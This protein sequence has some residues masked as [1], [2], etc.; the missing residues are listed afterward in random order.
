MNKI[1]L[2]LVACAMLF[3][4]AAN[5]VYADWEVGRWD[6]YEQLKIEAGVIESTAWYWADYLFKNDPA[7]VEMREKWA[8]AGLID[9]SQYGS[10]VITLTPYGIA[11]AKN[12][13]VDL[14]QELATIDVGGAEGYWS[15]ILFLD[16]DIC[17]QWLDAGFIEIVNYAATTKPED[18]NLTAYGELAIHNMLVTLKDALILIG[19]PNDNFVAEAKAK[20]LFMNDDMRNRWA[21]AGLINVTPLDIGNPSIDP[22]EINLTSYGNIAVKN[23]Y[24]LEQAFYGIGITQAGFPESWSD[25]LFTDHNM[26]SLWSKAGFITIHGSSGSVTDISLTYYGETAVLQMYNFIDTFTSAPLNIPGGGVTESIVQNLFSDAYMRKTWEDAGFIEIPTSP[27]GYDVWGVSPAYDPTDF[28]RYLVLGTPT[29]SS[30]SSWNSNPKGIITPHAAFLALDVAPQEAMANINEIIASYSTVLDASYGFHD[31]FNVNTSDVSEGYIALDQAMILI[32]ITNYLEAGVIQD[33]FSGSTIISNSKHLLNETFSMLE[34]P[35]NFSLD[36]NLSPADISTLEDIAARTWNYFSQTVDATTNWIP[37]NKVDGNGDDATYTSI[38]DIGLYLMCVASAYELDLIDLAEA[39]ERIEGALATLATLDKWNGLFRNYYKVETLDSPQEWMRFISTVDNGWLA[40]GLIVVGETFDS[41]KADADTILNAMDFSQLYDA[42]SGF[43][44]IGYDTTLGTLSEGHYGLI[45]TEIR[46]TLLIAIGKDGVPEEVWSNTNKVLSEGIAAQS[47]IPEG[48]YY[49]YTIEVAGVPEE[50]YYIPSWG[51]SMFE[52]LMPNL[53]LNNRTLSPNGYGIQDAVYVFLQ[54]YFATEDQLPGYSI[55]DSPIL[56]TPYGEFSIPG[57]VTLT[58]DLKGIGV[59]KIGVAEGIAITLFIDEDFRTDWEDA[60]Y[61]TTEY[62]GEL[63]VIGITITLLGETE[64]PNIVANVEQAVE[65]LDIAL[66]NN[67][68]RDDFELLFGIS[69][70]EQ[71]LAISNLYVNILTG[72]VSAD[73]YVLNDF[74][75]E[76][77]ES[78]ELYTALLAD[79]DLQTAFEAI[80]NVTVVDPALNPVFRGT[81]AGV[82]NMPEYD[83]AVYVQGVLELYEFHLALNA[84]RDEIVLLYGVIV[85]DQY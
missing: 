13:L 40:S 21:D 79:E 59:T 55:D 71:D 45:Y 85:A 16:N 56:I 18:I 14:K 43:L 68:F 63:R 48:D 38:T 11:A 47:Q 42:S 69:V 34:A 78:T 20:Y 74:L 26:R 25:F 66:E 28:D 58:I 51:G 70:A 81:L 62:D 83:F 60:D 72:I 24:D 64:I 5:A 82:V 53:V 49:T 29:G 77:T 80:E 1:I 61:I 33:A 2:I 84:V 23:M 65:D 35:D 22:T 17:A 54:K 37:S 31:S 75:E 8:T 73:T 41:L 30:A 32:S 7:N 6:L 10:D 67:S 9:V 52:G 50:V 12:M 57:M 19:I 15:E 3:G 39:T 4:V 76:L 46:P 36:R 44:S 27:Q